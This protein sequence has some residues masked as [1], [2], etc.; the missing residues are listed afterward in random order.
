VR[1]NGALPGYR[2][3]PLPR[4]FCSGVSWATFTEQEALESARR[5]VESCFEHGAFSVDVHI[6]QR[7]CIECWDGIRTYL[8]RSGARRSCKCDCQPYGGPV[9][10]S[11][12]I[13][14]TPD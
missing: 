4:I 3:F 9:V 13:T 12:G 7:R 14:L 2:A 6:E 8:T 5:Y 10:E 1:F 11:Y